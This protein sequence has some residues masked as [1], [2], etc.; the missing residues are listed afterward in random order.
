M[1]KS[2]LMPT[3]KKSGFNPDSLNFRLGDR[4]FQNDCL[5]RTKTK[6]MAY[7]DVDDIFIPQG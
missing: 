4:V 7:I 1:I 3:N 2:E 5:M 6:F